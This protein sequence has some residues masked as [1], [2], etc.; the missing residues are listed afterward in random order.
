MPQY[1]VVPKE[2]GGWALKGASAKRAV[3]VFE[4]QREAIERG[5]SLHGDHSLV[6]HGRDGKIRDES[7]Y[8][9]VADP[10]P[11]RG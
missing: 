1:H 2:N 4:T 9:R 11:P 7:T 5:K 10:F 3:G 8:P 6:I